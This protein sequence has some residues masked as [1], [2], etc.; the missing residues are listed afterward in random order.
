MPS[1]IPLRLT[2][3]LL[4][5][6]SYGWQGSSLAWKTVQAC[7]PKFLRK[8]PR[9]ALHVVG[10]SPTLSPPMLDVCCLLSLPFLYLYSFL[11]S[12]LHFLSFHPPA[13][14]HL[15]SFPFFPVFLLFCVCVVRACEC[16]GTYA[17]CTHE[18]AKENIVSP[19]HLFI[20]SLRQAFSL[21]WTLPFW[22]RWL[23][24][25]VLMLWWQVH[26]TMPG[27]LHGWWGF[28]LRF[29]YLLSE[30]FCPLNCLFRSPPSFFDSLLPSE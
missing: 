11:L 3:S 21:N 27:F 19:L 6:L 22:L 1:E 25:S 4:W 18:E 30:Y 20:I 16:A 15:P 2:F 12:S 17:M 28:K 23:S 26:V 8:E 5:T 9:E 14:P 10:M 7:V 13:L 24:C 29:S